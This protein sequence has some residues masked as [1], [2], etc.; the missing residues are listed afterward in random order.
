MSPHDLPGPLA[1]PAADA[2]GHEAIAARVQL[3]GDDPG[4]AFQLS[5][6]PA[7]TR[8]WMGLAGQASYLTLLDGDRRAR[9]QLALGA[10]G[11][12]IT[13][14]DAARRARAQ[15][16]LGAEGAG[17]A[18]LDETGEARVWLGLAGDSSYLGLVDSAGNVHGRLRLH[19]PAGLP[20]LVLADE[21]GLERANIAM[22][23]DG[24]RMDFL[25]P[26]GE[27][28][29]RLAVRATEASLAL[30]DAA[31]SPAAEIVVATGALLVL[32]EGGRRQVV[33]HSRAN[34]AELT[35]LRPDGGTAVALL[36]DCLPLWD[37]RGHLRAHLGLT[38]EGAAIRLFSG[39]GVQRAALE[40][41]GGPH[42]AIAGDQKLG[43]AEVRCGPAGPELR[44]S[45]E[46]GG[47]SAAWGIWD[48]PSGGGWRL[49]LA[50]ADGL[51]RAELRQSSG[52]AAEIELWDAAQPRL[53][54][55]PAP[56]NE[57][58][59]AAASDGE[60]TMV[61]LDGRGS[62]AAQV[63][64]PPE[65]ASP[66][67]AGGATRD[68]GARQAGTGADG[69]LRL[70]PDGPQL[71]LRP[72]LSAPMRLAVEAGAATLWR[73]A[74]AG[75]AEQP[76]LRTGAGQ[77]RLS[78]IDGRGRL[79]GAWEAGADGASLSLAGDGDQPQAQLLVT[80]DGLR[81]GLMAPELRAAPAWFGMGSD[82]SSYLG[83]LPETGPIAGMLAINDDQITLAFLDP[84]AHQRAELAVDGEGPRLTLAAG[85]RRAQAEIRMQAGGPAIAFLDNDGVARGWL[86]LET[87]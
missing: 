26:A 84:A 81:L 56:G 20:A 4:I 66:L 36:A 33:V 5:G 54:Q 30:V 25:S 6:A 79:R 42:L 37:A 27:V 21:Q 83:L 29:A 76:W 46:P 34:Q 85:N 53:R 55:Q 86:A 22:D 65:L 82:A 12:K 48:H 28:V 8:A 47:A 50:G 43:R 3:G 31:G 44:L 87:D 32:R 13:L 67:A 10:D 80:G 24:P 18:L 1:P 57:M 7:E 73:A 63:R 78:I 45:A 2:A 77:A 23:P 52:G 58:L 14:A 19:G 51:G 70:G 40:T 64:L 69:E 38:G 11:P 75:H 68:G 15:V 59:G 74:G 35:F 17:I 72:E 49:S 62:P 41:S 9:G 71:I 60:S 16:R 39:D 61:L